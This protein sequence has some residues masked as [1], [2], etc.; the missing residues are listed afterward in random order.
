MNGN[1]KID[2]KT[3]LKPSIEAFLKNIPSLGNKTRKGYEKI[4]DSFL[5]F[6]K[7]NRTGED[8]PVSISQETFVAWINS[9]KPSYCLITVQGHARV[10]ARFLRFLQ[11]TG[12]LK[13][14]AVGLLQKRYP[15]N[16]LTGI[17][18]AL[19][20]PFPKESLQS[21]R[22]PEKFTSPLGSSMEKFISLGR[23][24]GKRYRN[25]E[26]ILCRFDR[27]LR[28]Y[29]DPPRNLS[30]PVLKKW[31]T[32]S[33][34]CQPSSRYLNF[35]V[36]RR[37]CLYLSRF[38]PNVYIPDIS[39]VQSKS[40][41]LLPYVYS[42]AEIAAFLKAARQLAPSPV[43]PIRPQTYYFLFLLLYTTGMR[44]S[45]ALNLE[46]S[47]IDW[48]NQTLHIREAKFFKSRLV[49]LSGS[50]A[51]ELNNYVQYR[52]AAGLTIDDKAPLFQ[53]PHR[54]GH[55]S[56]STVTTTF[57]GICRQL[58]VR[59]IDGRRNPCIHSF[60]HTMA[61]HRLEDWYRRGEDVQTKLRL[62]SIYLGHTKIASTQR[63]LTMTA[64]LLQQASECFRR[65]SDADQIGEEK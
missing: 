5:S 10:I 32:H 39:L 53:N 46:F 19:L 65:Y 35:A 43:S 30:D 29:S 6:L 57:S 25:E 47:D 38:N 23:S 18:S 51:Q 61:V 45:E 31:L 3:E 9:V 41:T 64:E 4:I 50:V 8:F 59:P 17:V 22:Q 48:K 58:N 27:F 7:T 13:H 36:V 56:K 55:L 15:R 42:R 16:G 52:Q 14:N 21:L 34:T 11:D 2:I 1:M 20:G 37:F 63:Y 28:S 12:M 26:E 49:P 33:Q 60:R 40:P 44:I 24:Q 62:L 54:I